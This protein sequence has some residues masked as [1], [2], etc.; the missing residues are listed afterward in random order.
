MPK[1]PDKVE[2]EDSILVKA[3]T[4]IGRS[5]GK[6]AGF[7]SRKK[8]TQSEPTKKPTRKKSSRT[9]GKK[10]AAGKTRASQEVKNLARSGSPKR[11]SKA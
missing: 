10:V 1:K 2:N 5:V 9:T 3:T 11:K 8:T 6:L 7:V 4:T